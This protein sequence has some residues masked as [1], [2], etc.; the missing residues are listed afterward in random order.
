MSIL[1]RGWRRTQVKRRRTKPGSSPFSTA[2]S[3]ITKGL[4]L[5]RL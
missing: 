5:K 1:Q 4:P 3:V 2:H